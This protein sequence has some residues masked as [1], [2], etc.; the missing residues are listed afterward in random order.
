MRRARCQGLE[1]MQDARSGRRSAVRGKER[2]Y[3]HGSATRVS[4]AL[5]AETDGIDAGMS[6]D[7]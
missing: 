7:D 4:K 1:G 5:R 6:E 3:R 2:H